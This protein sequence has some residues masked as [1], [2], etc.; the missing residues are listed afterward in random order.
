MKTWPYST[1]W[2]ICATLLIWGGHWILGG[3]LLAV[4]IWGIFIK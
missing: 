4:A 2:A 3:I 1:I